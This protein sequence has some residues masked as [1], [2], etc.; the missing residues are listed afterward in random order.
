MSNVTVRVKPG[1]KK[2]PLIQPALDGSLLVY[3]REPAVDGK[4]N[5]AV[6]E[7]LSAYFDVPK[8]RVQLVAGLTAPEKR[9]K[10]G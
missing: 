10:I 6:V 4:A 3:V 8:N 1:S 9:F 7:L 5:R 2:G